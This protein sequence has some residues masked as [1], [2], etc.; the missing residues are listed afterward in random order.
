MNQLSVRLL[1]PFEVIGDGDPVT[2][3][4]GDATRALLAYL[5]MHAG[6]ELRRDNLAGLLWPDEP[7]A[8]ALRNLR[9]ALHRL[10]ASIRDLEADPPLLRTTR[11]VI[12]FTPGSSPPTGSPE[13]ARAQ[14]GRTFWLDV[15]AF[16]KALAETAAHSHDA[17]ERCPSCIPRQEEAVHLYRGEFL[18]GFSYPSDLYE[19]WMV[20][21]REALHGQAL[22]ALAHLATYHGE[23][24]ETAQAIRYAQ[25]QVELE[26]WRE[27]AHRQWIRAL[28]WS[29]QRGAAMAQFEACQRILAD[30]LG[31]EPEEETTALYERIRDG[32]ELPPHAPIPPHNLPA[33]ATPF[34]G[35]QAQVANVIALLTRSDVRLLTL[36]GPG[37]TGKTR[38]ALQAASELL[39]EVPD[40]VFFVALAPVRDAA[41]VLPTIASTLGVREAK[42][43]SL[44]AAWDESVAPVQAGSVLEPLQYYLRD[45]QLLLVVDNCEHVLPAA[46]VLNELL[47]AAPGLHILATSRASLRVYGEHEYLV[48]PMEVPAPRALPSFERLAHSEAVQL[49]VQRAQAVRPDFTLGEGNVEAVA[50]ICAQLDGLPLAVELAAAR[51]KL[52]SPQAMLPRLED[53]LQFLT[54]GPRDAPARQRTLRATIDWSYGLL[55]ADERTLFRRLAVFAGGCSLQAVEA[56]CLAS[57]DL[58]GSLV[59]QHLLRSSEVAGQPRFTM[60]ETIRE[61]A[62]E[63]LAESGESEEVRRRHATFYFAMAVESEPALHRYGVR[64]AA[65]MDRLEAELDNLRAALA[66][67][68]EHE[69]ELGLRL[70]VALGRF[71]EIR[72]M[73]FEGRDWLTQALAASADRGAELMSLRAQALTWSGTLSLYTDPPAAASLE[74]QSLA[75]WRELGDEHGIAY[76]LCELAMAEYL[77]GD[78]AVARPRMEEGLALLRQTDD[79]VGLVRALY[80][81]A[82]MVLQQDDYEIARASAEESGRLG[83]EIGA[84]AHVATADRSLG[85]IAEALGDYA[86]AQAAYEENLRLAREA[87]DQLSAEQCL[88]SLG[89]VRYAQA[90]YERATTYWEVVLDLR[91]A[92]GNKDAV[93]HMLI[94]LGELERLQGDDERATTFYEE[95]LA[96][97]RELDDK[98]LTSYALHDLGHIAL[99][100]REAQRAAALFA[101][102]LVL[103]QE[104]GDEIVLPACLAGLAGVAGAEGD[105]ERAARLFGAADTIWE[106]AGRDLSRADQAEYDRNLALARV[107]L[108]EDA[109]AAAWDKGR[110]MATKGREQTVAYA[111]ETASSGR[112]TV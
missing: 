41:H 40:G 103:S 55:N 104:S 65:W 53:R 24:G 42:G 56:V 83:R 52:L 20:V 44:G 10:R 50:E 36:T 108:D 98:R 28:A 75:L 87:K 90:D 97:A 4:G 85:S 23:R 78:L 34:I 95:G 70:A 32:A 25:R 72:P 1:G 9:Q 77:Q 110:E 68:I 106:A 109:F 111:L 21:E 38:L 45:K 11:R 8:A 58:L 107:G 91:R 96:L 37:G 89:H 100:R 64:Q 46:P 84:M 54:G 47:S 67:S 49:F 94:W 101:E 12:A 99:H 60:L 48:P 93:T 29:G 82:V 69:I 105:W 63:R 57:L 33:Q 26:P 2:W 43:R 30:E 79:R 14:E 19:G 7:Q 102:S 76:A 22:E 88:S 74:R 18:A 27:E 6:S 92:S 39:R 112:S 61:Y 80:W 31:V 17:L 86:T 81:Y 15:T 73:H 3:A 62:T 5:V 71:W 59:D 35:R 16:R 13:T 66:W 51:V